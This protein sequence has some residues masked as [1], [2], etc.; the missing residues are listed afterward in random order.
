MA[1]GK[2]PAAKLL[3]DEQMRKYV[4]DGYVKI[5]PEVPV[6]VHETVR[7]KLQ[8]IT[9]EEFNYGNNVLPKV[10]EMD[11]IL[12]SPEVR[13]ALISVIGPGYIEH[14]HRYC[15]HLGPFSNNKTLEENCHQDSY[16]PLGRPRQHYSRF[17]RI[18]YY[19]Q[20]T[21]VEIGP[22]HV[23]AGSQY[24]KRLTDEDRKKTIPVSGE[25]GT[26]FLTHFD[27]GHAAGINKSD[28]HRHMIKFIYVRAQEPTEPS[29]DCQDR[30]WHN[31]EHLETPYDLSLPWS[32][33]WDWL[34]GKDDRYESF[35]ALDFDRV[36]GA[37]DVLK[38]GDR[39]A[40][41][42]AMCSIA[43]DKEIGA[44]PALMAKLNDTEEPWT[45]LA[46][47][48]ALGALGAPAV[49]PLANS[50]VDSSADKDGDQVSASWNEAATTMEDEAHALAAIGAP[51]LARLTDLL[52]SESEWIRI[53]AAF[54]LGEMD[55]M[56]TNAVGA[57]TQCLVDD[58]HCVV[59]TATDAL[60]SIKR[61]SG[62]F[63]PS[64]E[65]LLKSGRPEWDY[66][67][68]RDWTPN[69]QVRCNAA[70]AFARLGNEAALAENVLLDAL[71][72]PNGQVAKFALDALGRI[73]TPSATDG[74]MQYLMSRRW[75][76]SILKNRQF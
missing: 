37:V 43:A 15:H 65:R 39:Q 46:A 29:W 49:K 51:S 50:L 21:P 1:Y 56:A 22:T 20:D 62:E 71:A 24:H 26:V 52:K 34:C 57:L 10:P 58:S 76:E 47:V 7:N 3:N 25:A 54:G 64:L 42:A 36:D 72:D 27:I 63:I 75:D 35:R 19:P 31:P 66:V 9:D 16:T 12:N 32:H 11:R 55:G 5:K 67:A 17:A 2:Q 70:M 18:M 53:N 14:P 41:I 23:I 8:I 73:G 4:A 6:E 68:K 40:Q 59:R 45:R 60:S 48:Y 30:F 44:I 28:K 74:A 69:D 13:G 38:S 33:M 61:S